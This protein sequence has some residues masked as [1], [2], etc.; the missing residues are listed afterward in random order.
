MGATAAYYISATMGWRDAYILG[1]VLGLG[2][3]VLRSRIR[4]SGMYHKMEKKEKK[5]SR[6]N[7]LLF[8]K[9]PELLKKYLMVTLIGA[10]I[11][12][13][14]GVFITF[15]PEFAKAFGMT[16]LP[17]PGKAVLFCY[18]AA[19]FAGIFIGI[20]SQKL[21]SRK[22]AI[23]ISF[24]SLIV[25]TFLYVTVRTDSLPVFYILCGA[26]GLGGAYSPMFVQV[27][28]EQFG[29][30][31]RATA[32]TSIPN[33]VRGL[34]IPMTMG[35]RALIPMMGV[36]YSGVTVMA[37]TVTLALISLWNLRETFHV[38]LDYMEGQ[39]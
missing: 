23:L 37:V 25:A 18:G 6:G 36:A 34:T 12:A 39:I 7:I 19:A 32:A 29:T 30:N 14:V 24:L 17:D 2:L 28:A 8:F 9:K 1:G 31:I 13:I 26:M 5:S 3:L 4:E 11:W 20:I 33:V 15:S 21:R 27:A 16:V 35:F 22:K 38:D 10:P